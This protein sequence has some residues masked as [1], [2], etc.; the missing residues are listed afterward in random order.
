MPPEA[1]LRWP[2]FCLLFE[3]PFRPGDLLFDVTLVERCYPFDEV[4]GFA[5]VSGT[6]TMA[7]ELLTRRSQLDEL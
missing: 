6:P 3:A 5:V 2:S 7:P 1:T 4:R